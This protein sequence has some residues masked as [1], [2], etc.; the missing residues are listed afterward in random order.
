MNNYAKRNWSEYNKKLINRGSITFWLDQECLNSWVQKTG[1]KGR[2][3]FS[4]LVIQAGWIIKSVYRLSLRALQGFL[5]SILKLLQLEIKSPHYSLFCKRAKEAAESLHKLSNKLPT[6]LVI[7]S[8]GL[9]V[10]GEGEWKVKIHGSEK[11]RGWI[12]LHIAIDP[13]TQELIAVEFTNDKI[14]DSAVLPKLVDKSPKSVRK[15]LADGA[16][17]K[18]S[19]RQYLL[20][21]KIEGCIPP[22]RHGRQRKG[23]EFNERNSDLKVISLLG[24]DEEAFDLWKKLVGYH[25]RSL[26]ESAF[27]RLKRLFGD[28]LNNKTLKNLEAETLFRCHVL[29]R[30]NR[31]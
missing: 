24:G 16:Y 1:K 7:D 22:R 15:V 18:A 21:R 25:K 23:E 12:K 5:R 27:S 11:H 8:S 17:D 9:K 10:T 3:S 2:P 14:A 28:R 4:K 29:N 20:K 13:K 6:D 31:I 26:V 19:C 30:M